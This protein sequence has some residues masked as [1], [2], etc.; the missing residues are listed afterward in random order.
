MRTMMV[1]CCYPVD[2]ALGD[3]DYRRIVYNI[4]PRYDR[5]RSDIVRTYPCEVK[6]GSG[7]D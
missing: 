1:Q 6:R 3:I 2:R 7:K 4:T 5:T